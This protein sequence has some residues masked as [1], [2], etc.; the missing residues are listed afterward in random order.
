[1]ATQP[2]PGL[3]YG[4]FASFPPSIRTPSIWDAPSPRAIDAGI[5]DADEQQ[6]AARARRPTSWASKRAERQQ[7]VVTGK[8]Q[9]LPGWE[10]SPA[11]KGSQQASIHDMIDWNIQNI[12]RVL[13]T[14]VFRRGL[15]TR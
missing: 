11:L 9:P 2:P 15:A 1:M 5:G 12:D 10:V 8:K 13:G 6:A 4:P 14:A 3:G 7:L